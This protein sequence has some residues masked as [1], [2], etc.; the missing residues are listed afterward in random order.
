MAPGEVLF[1]DD[2]QANVDAAAAL[3][4]PALRFRV[5]EQ[6]QQDLLDRGLQ[7]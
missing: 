3:G 2:R 1:V 7:F 6:L 5:A 4:I